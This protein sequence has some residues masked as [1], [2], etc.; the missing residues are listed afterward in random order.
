M[1]PTRKLKIECFYSPL[2]I[3]S[4]FHRPALCSKGWPRPMASGWVW[5]SGTEQEM[6]RREMEGWCL[7]PQLLP[8][9]LLS[10]SPLHT[11]LSLVL[12]ST[13]FSYP[14]KAPEWCWYLIVPGH[15][16][17]SIFVNGPQ[18]AQLDMPSLSCHDPQTHQL[19]TQ[20]CYAAKEIIIFFINKSYYVCN[21]LWSTF[22]KKM[23]WCI[24]M[25]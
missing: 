12:V 13:L 7:F 6:G 1:L 8:A 2:L 16:T 20:E 9:F 24:E 11:V 25:R 18:V 22:F 14:H 19:I 23:N 5:L 15:S 21:L 3:H 4:T 10:G 17:I